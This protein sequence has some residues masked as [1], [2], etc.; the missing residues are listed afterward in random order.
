MGKT[1]R[2]FSRSTSTRQPTNTHPAVDAQ[3][4][5][6]RLGGVVYQFSSKYGGNIDE[7][8]PIWTPETRQPGS[9]TYEPGLLGIAVWFVGFAGL[10]A[11]GGFAI[12]TTSALAN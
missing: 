6:A 3:G 11:T 2:D 5:K 12:Y 1:N 4:R 7:Y 9:D 8:S 10:L